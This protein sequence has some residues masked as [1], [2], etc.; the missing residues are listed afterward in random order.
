MRS[1][2]IYGLGPHGFHQIHYTEWGDADNPHILVCVH[3]LTR[4]SRD[5]DSLAAVL[6]EDYRVICPD[7]PGRGQSAWLDDKSDYNYSVYLADMAVLL[8]R[9]HSEKVDWIGTSMGGIIG[10]LLASQ[11]NT[12]IHRLL[13]NDIG[14]NISKESLNRIKEYAGTD[15][16]FTNRLEVEKY[17]RTIYKSFGPLTDTQ[18]R[19]IARFSTR[20]LPDSRLALHFDPGIVMLFN[21]A[22][23]EAIDLWDVWDQIQCPVM[24]LRGEE[25]D[26]LSADTARAMGKRGPK[27]EVVEFPGIG[28]APALMALDQIATIRKWC[29]RH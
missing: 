28:H 16:A 24:V 15:P 2:F 13:L 8:G 20:L 18:W 6:A 25:S 12:A 11:P 22:S 7:I 23:I 9:L 4:N 21:H 17:L 1:D 14:P 3:G 19:H 27:A 26:I 10:M 29:A 5:F